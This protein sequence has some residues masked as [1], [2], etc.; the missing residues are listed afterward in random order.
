MSLDLNNYSCSSVGLL[1]P[2]INEYTWS[3][4]TRAFL[5]LA[6]MFWC[7]LAVAIIA[8]IFMCSIERITSK[9]RMVKIADSDAKD[10][11]Q[12]LEVKVWNDTVANLSLMALGTSAPEIMLSVVEIIKN[13]FKAGEL[14]PSTIVGSAAFNL[15]CITAV[16]IVSIEKGEV[17]KI[18]AIKVYGVTAFFCIFAY[19]WLILVLMVMS[20]GQVELWEAI[21]TFLFFPVLILVAY[22]A[23]KD[24]CCRKNQTTVSME[25]GLGNY[26]LTYHSV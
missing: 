9:T 25:I 4:G 22:A 3:T 5:Y 11:Y 23:D 12:V 24:P 26:H 18:S 8:D 19:V 17:R 7:F 2:A 6:G 10:G 21:V 1:L 15:L 20:P 14:G 16:C 13:Q